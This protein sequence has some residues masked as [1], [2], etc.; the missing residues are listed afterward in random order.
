MD[1]LPRQCPEQCGIKSPA[2]PLPASLRRQIDGDGDCRVIGRALVVAVRTGPT[3][4]LA[5][6][7]RRKALIAPG[8]R[9]AVEPG[10]AL[11]Q[12]ARL[13][14]EGDGRFA[15]VEIINL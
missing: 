11:L 3:D 8:R 15:H 5:V 12:R 14:V 10:L 7:Y 1:V 13:D 9:E 6:P 2:Q 4:R